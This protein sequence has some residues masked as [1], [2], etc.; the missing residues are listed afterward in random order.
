MFKGIKRTKNND[1]VINNKGLSV[2]NILFILSVLITLFFFIPVLK[3]DFSYGFFGDDLK[4]SFS[5]FSLA[6]LKLDEYYLSGLSGVKGY[7]LLFIIYPLVNIAMWLLNK[8]ATGKG[9]YIFVHV[10]YLLNISLGF[11]EFIIMNALS[12]LHADEFKG[13]F[14]VWIFL[15]ILF[16]NLIL[17]VY[18][19]LKTGRTEIDENAVAL[20]MNVDYAKGILNKAGSVATNVASNVSAAASKAAASKPQNTAKEE[21]KLNTVVCDSCGNECPETSSF[22]TKCGNNLDNA[23]KVKEEAPNYVDEAAKLAR[24]MATNENNTQ[25][26]ETVQEVPVETVVQAP[27]ET[28]AESRV[29][30]E[31]AEVNVEERK[32]DTA[33]NG[34]SLSK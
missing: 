31:I 30:P 9:S 24:E 7:T 16:I 12:G 28:V 1:L 33:S 10:I 14:F 32:E 23:K 22:C 25:T 13:T 21:V 11:T 18:G 5:L 29:E 8:K 4:K 34:V 3:I 2:L 19:I 15:I 20:D 17:S 26:V 6:S 27:V